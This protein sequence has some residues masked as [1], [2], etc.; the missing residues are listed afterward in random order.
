VTDFVEVR[1]G[2]FLTNKYSY[3]C[4]LYCDGKGGG[5]LNKTGM[6]LIREGDLFAKW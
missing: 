2:G 4:I 5:G 3:L 1:G 6:W